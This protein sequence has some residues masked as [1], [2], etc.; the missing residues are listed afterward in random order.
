MELA[1]MTVQR[2]QVGYLAN[3]FISCMVP[4]S[5]ENRILTGAGA[6]SGRDNKFPVLLFFGSHRL[7]S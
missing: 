6:S 4:A 2:L 5:N 1:V 7:V 3:S